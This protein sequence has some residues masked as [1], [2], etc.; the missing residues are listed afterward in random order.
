[1]EKGENPEM[2]ACAAETVFHASRLVGNCYGQMTITNEY[3]EYEQAGNCH[4]WALTR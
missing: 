3:V 4:R 1:M 2:F